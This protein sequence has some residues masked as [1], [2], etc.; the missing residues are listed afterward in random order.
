MEHLIFDIE[1][2][3]SRRPFIACLNLVLNRVIMN[4]CCAIFLRHKGRMSGAEQLL[5]DEDN[6]NSPKA[7]AAD[8]DQKEATAAAISQANGALKDLNL[9]SAS[10]P[11]APQA[12]DIDT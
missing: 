4:T 5:G 12:M 11:R 7:P 8:D 1:L 2:R 9:A 3:N 10:A 6:S